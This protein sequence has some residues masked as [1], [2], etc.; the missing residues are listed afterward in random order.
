[1]TI[2]CLC[3]LGTARVLA[4][5]EPGSVFPGCRALQTLRGLSGPIFSSLT[6]G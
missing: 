2:L 6:Q 1:M 5:P 4:G 3:G